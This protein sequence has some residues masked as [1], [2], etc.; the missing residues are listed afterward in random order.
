LFF[1]AGQLLRI[2]FVY[3]ERNGMERSG[4]DPE[5]EVE[6]VAALFA[7]RTHRILNKEAASL[8]VHKYINNT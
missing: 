4:T 1:G 2:V 7:M 5:T 8:E 3:T 6:V